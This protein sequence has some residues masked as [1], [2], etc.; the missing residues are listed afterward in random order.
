MSIILRVNKGSALTYDEMDRNQAQFFYSSSLRNS[1]QTMRLH[2]T[3]SN[4]LDLAGVD[5]GPERYEEINFPAQAAQQSTTSAAG[6]ITEVQFNGGPVNGVDI[7]KADSNFVWNNTKKFLSLAS[8][9]QERLS[10]GVISDSHAAGISLTA[11][12]I[13]ANEGSKALI[14]FKEDS[15]DG[16]SNS[17]IGK[18]SSVNSHFYISQNKVIDA[19]RKEYG[20]IHNSIVGNNSGGVEGD[21]SIVGTFS[22]D[23]DIKSLGIGTT[24]PT[25][26]LN[27]AG[28][29]GIGVGI[30]TGIAV[31]S[32]IKP[33]PSSINTASSNGRRT[34]IPVDSNTAGLL[35]SSPAGPDGGN[36]VVNINTDTNQKEGFNVI[37]TTENEF[38]NP[39]ADTLLTVT[40]AGRTGVNTNYPATNGL[41]VAGNISGSGF[42]EIDQLAGPDITVSYQDFMPLGVKSDG[43]FVNTS[44]VGGLTPLGGIIIWSGAANAIPTGWA[45]CDGTTSN[46]QVTPNLVSRFIMGAASPTVSGSAVGT[47]GGS[48]DAVIVAHGHSATVIEGDGHQHGFTQENTRGLGASGAKDGTSSFEAA[49]TDK[50]TTGI[51]VTIQSAT[52]GESG[53]NK[54]L[55]P[56]YALC[57]IMYVGIAP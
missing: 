21:D 42:V 4:A 44:T 47:V 39:K 35:I 23:N 7:F 27:V 5:Y 32:F 2:Y 28:E 19:S 46:S 43:R 55:P 41:T 45:I 54:N 24:S 12:P 38:D 6:D 57:Y 37:S 1:G 51:S 48:K 53:T 18:I 16:A 17:V 33:I 56:Y 50:A 8:N 52:G 29:H 22:F 15:A 31:E 10:I 9:S 40:A 34:L 13:F 36:V 3:G 26:N 14:R 11:N 30:G 25:K 20:K 49:Q